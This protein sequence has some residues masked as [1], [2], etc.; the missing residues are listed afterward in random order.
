MKPHS[1]ACS[2]I[3]LSFLVSACTPLGSSQGTISNSPAH[4][5]ADGSSPSPASAAEATEP[6]VKEARATGN[7]TDQ[8]KP[9]TGDAKSAERKAAGSRRPANS[10]GTNDTKSAS[11]EKKPDPIKPYDKVITKEAKTSRGLFLVH[12]VDDKVYFEI[13]TNELGR[14]FLW[15]S[16]VERTQAGFGYG[17]GSHLGDRV[18]R[19]ELHNKDVLFR[20]V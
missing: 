15:V 3:L 7:K 20:S 1:F 17:G 10:S 6:T 13:P 16:Q 12:R 5:R 2:L 19:W 4:K 9:K 14:E 8:A 18:V 11:E